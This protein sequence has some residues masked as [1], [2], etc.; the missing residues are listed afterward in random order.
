M[1]AHSC[2]QVC[3]A[4]QRHKTL[5][6]CFSVSCMS[7]RTDTSVN[8]PTNLSVRATASLQLRSRPGTRLLRSPD[9]VLVAMPGHFHRVSAERGR[10]TGHVPVFLG[11]RTRSSQPM[12]V[13]VAGL[14]HRSV[15]RSNSL[16]YANFGQQIV[17]GRPA[18][19]AAK[20]QSTQTTALRCARHWTGA[21]NISQKYTTHTA[22][23][24]C[25][26]SF[27]EFGRISSNLGEGLSIIVQ[28]LT[29]F[30]SILSIFLIDI[31]GR[32]VTVTQQILL[33]VLF[34]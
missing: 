11:E 18:E 31:G 4:L 20:H 16:I 12:H 29:Q 6:H 7:H 26:A 1:R 34:E 3:H 25:S 30:R 13:I 10:P 27:D 28:M 17:P 21:P 14:E 24:I 2:G 9:V 5:R 33:G 23:S 22:G 8:Q 19:A 32:G 15:K